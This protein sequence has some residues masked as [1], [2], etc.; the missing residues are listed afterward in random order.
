MWRSLAA[1]RCAPT[2]VYPPRGWNSPI[3]R[4]IVNVYWAVTITALKMVIAVPLAVALVGSIGLLWVLFI[5]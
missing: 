2:G 1:A 4:K 3:V 5:L